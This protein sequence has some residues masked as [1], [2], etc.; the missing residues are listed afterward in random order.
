MR[1]A[2]FIPALLILLLV[3]LAARAIDQDTL[4]R[5]VFLLQQPEWDM[6]GDGVFDEATLYDG[7]EEI[8]ATAKDEGNDILARKALWAMGETG[9]AA[10]APTLVGAIEDEPITVCFAL[11]KVSSEDGVHA[12]IE[13]LD[14]EDEQIRDAA[15]WGLGNV[16]YISGLEEAQQEALDALAARLD[17]EEEDWVR[18]DILAAITLIET[19]LATN[20]AFMEPLDTQ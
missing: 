15:A 16:P 9:L 2:I 5:F 10:F 14:N 17:T 11:G 4:D 7:L 6:W 18:E 12:L 8:Y 3:P 1:N 13:A 19:G 20:E